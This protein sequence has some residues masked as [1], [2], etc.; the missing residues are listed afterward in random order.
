MQISFVF[1]QHTSLMIAQKRNFFAILSRKR[2]VGRR[3]LLKNAISL[4]FSMIILRVQH[5]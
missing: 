5:P 2:P 4:Q 1:E 3:R